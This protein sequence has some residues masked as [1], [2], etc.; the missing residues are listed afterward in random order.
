MRDLVSS[1]L[2]VSFRYSEDEKT[3]RASSWSN[4][5]RFLGSGD[6]GS[7]VGL[8][9]ASSQYDVQWDALEDISFKFFEN[10]KSKLTGS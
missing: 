10:E 1:V 3:K 5:E 7:T 8:L 6:P 9:G 4:S 2:Q